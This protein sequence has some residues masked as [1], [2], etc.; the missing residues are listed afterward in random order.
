M[1]SIFTFPRSF[2]STIPILGCLCLV[3]C[4]SSGESV[5]QPGAPIAPTEPSEEGAG[6]P[7][8]TAT[9]PADKC[10]AAPKKS[11]CKNG[12]SWVRGVA[13]FDPSHFKAGSKPV[14]RVVLRHSFALYKGEENIGGR[15]HA[16]ASFPVADPTKGEVGFAL[17]MCSTGTA[18][19]SEENGAFH[20]VLILDEDGN[21]DLDDA[22]SNEKAVIVATPGVKELVK[23]VD[24]DLSCN[25]PS[26]CL[27]VN[28][29]CTGGASCTTIEPMKSCKRKATG[30]KSDSAFCG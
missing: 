24:V 28:I 6:T 1:R 4:G 22:T 13:H 9:P 20:L 7:E 19:W 2:P 8:E 10:G 21:N 18:M 3:A 17:D 16:W 12:G 30:C 29:D 23:M 15:L 14:L 25:A 27:D 5:A 26:P 11:A